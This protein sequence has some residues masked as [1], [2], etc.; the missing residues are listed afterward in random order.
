MRYQVSVNCRLRQFAHS[1]VGEHWH[2]DGLFRKS[3]IRNAK[4]LML[5]PKA[6]V[7]NGEPSM[8]RRTDYTYRSVFGRRRWIGSMNNKKRP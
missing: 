8:A 2:T 7:D 3:K 1:A 4:K 6:Q 5:E